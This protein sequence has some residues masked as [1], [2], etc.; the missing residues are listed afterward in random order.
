MRRGFT[1]FELLLTLMIIGIVA[2][3][4]VPRFTSTNAGSRLDAAE[5]RI[6]A[7]LIAARDLARARGEP[8]VVQVNTSTDTV[9][10]FRSADR[11]KNGMLRNADLGDSPYAVDISSTSISNK[12]GYIV[13]D[14]YG[15]F[16]EGLKMHLQSGGVTR[17]LTVS[18]PV[19]PSSPAPVLG[20]G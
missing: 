8:L 9:R 19:D 16:A 12:Y 7:E 1:L 3:I 2:A 10:V 5:Q 4:A 20:G 18:L 13:V 17:T 14:G 6:T 15:T 11:T